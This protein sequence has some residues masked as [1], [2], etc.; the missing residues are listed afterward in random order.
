[1]NEDTVPEKRPYLLQADAEALLGLLQ[2]IEMKVEMINRIAH[3]TPVQTYRSA[4]ASG[5][6]IETEFQILN[7]L[8]AEKA[9]QLA[10]TENQLFRIFCRW[11]GV[12]MGSEVGVEFYVVVVE[13]F[14]FFGVEV[15]LPCCGK[16]EVI[17]DKACGDDGGFFVFDDGDGFFGV[18]GEEVFSEEALVEVEWVDVE[19]FLYPVYVVEGAADSF[20]GLGVVEHDFAAP[21]V[22]PK[23]LPLLT[24]FECFPAG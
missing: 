11:E 5:V 23:K 19:G 22:V 20:A 12:F 7:T 13:W 10:V 16:P 15:P 24:G 9:A 14:E 8:L 1:M 18:G 4:V 2:A 17:G 6:V 3:L 21:D